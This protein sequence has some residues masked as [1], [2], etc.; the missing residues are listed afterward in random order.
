MTSPKYKWNIDKSCYVGT[1][2]ATF[3]I[4]FSVHYHDSITKT[5][6]KLNQKYTDKKY[7]CISYSK[8][9]NKYYLLWNSNITNCNIINAF[10]DYTI[11]LSP[12]IKYRN[13]LYDRNKNIYNE[14][15]KI[16]K[17]YNMVLFY[18]N[19][20]DDLVMIR[21]ICVIQNVNDYIYDYEPLKDQPIRKLTL[22]NNLIIEIFI[23]FPEQKLLNI[24]QDE[25]LK[26]F[27]IFVKEKFDDD[28]I[29]QTDK[30]IY[31]LYILDSYY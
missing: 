1:K 26:F 21:D 19:N 30:V 4:D 25:A 7:F 8:R 5:V 23:N 18:K 27:S 14:Y 12:S 2:F 31:T 29:C 17:N 9:L 10:I 22:S 16:N 20:P 24:P 13:L 11:S 28:V 15:L 6:E 3:F